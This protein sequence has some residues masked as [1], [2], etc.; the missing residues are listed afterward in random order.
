[1]KIALV[2]TLGAVLTSGCG[3]DRARVAASV[4][5]CN[6]ASPTADFDCGEGYLC[7]AAAD[8]IGGSFCAPT[9][10][11]SDPKSCEGGVCTV[12][13]AC[14]RRCK[15][16]TT[17]ACGG[18]GS[19]LLCARRTGTLEPDGLDGICIPV[20]SLCSTNADCRSSVYDL[21]GTTSPMDRFAGPHPNDGLV[22]I[23]GSCVSGGTECVP[24]SSCIRKVV[25][26]S[27][28]AIPDVCTPNC[29][30]RSVPGSD[31]GLVDECMLGLT[32]LSD[33]LP[34]TERRVCVPGFPGFLCR[35][36]LGCISGACQGWDDVAP[37][38][39]EFRTCD[40]PCSRDEDCL[41][42][43][44]SANPNAFSKFMCRGGRCRN[45]LSLGFP[46]LCLR[47]KD[48]CKLDPAAECRVPTEIVGPP[49]DGGAP[50][51]CATQF[52]LGAGGSTTVTCVRRCGGDDDCARLSSGSHVKHVCILGI[53]LPTLPYLTPCSSTSQCLGSLTCEKATGGPP[54]PVCTLRCNSPTDCAAHPALGASFACY[55]GLCVPRTR[56]G[57]PPPAPLS[58]LCL[59]GELAQGQCVSPTGWPCGTNTECKSGSCRG[60]RCD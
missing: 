36:K 8:A 57:C 55:Q 35:N 58:E 53:C 34:Q 10:V 21:C 54:Y 42:H 18:A 52:S 12:G 37:E 59:G 14:L 38:M 41:E 33:V 47:E 28:D 50:D 4:F 23:Q 5:T 48:A 51:N 49:P 45:Q 11:A 15:V 46:E 29:V 9:C 25:P 3:D 24:G 44:G 31:G 40:P 19:P 56:A 1:V 20:S 39:A 7:Y 27:F 13:G 26:G 43:D 6:P 16:G 60:N 30:A 22:C 32:C 17:D 2:L